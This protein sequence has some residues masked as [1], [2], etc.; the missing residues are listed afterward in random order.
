MKPEITRLLKIFESPLT[1]KDIKNHCYRLNTTSIYKIK[2]FII[3]NKR[4]KLLNREAYMQSYVVKYAWG[5]A[6]DGF[7]NYSSLPE[8][9]KEKIRKEYKDKAKDIVNKKIAEL[10]ANI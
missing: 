5:I 10:C 6:G 4:S 3:N 2:A 1:L 7:N 9:T 8:R